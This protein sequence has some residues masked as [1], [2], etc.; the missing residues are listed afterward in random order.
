MAG[1]VGAASSTK[2]VVLADRLQPLPE[3]VYVY[4]PADDGLL[5][6]LSSASV[7][8]VF[9]FEPDAAWSV[10][11]RLVGLPTLLSIRMAML[12]SV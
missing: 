10:T 5:S 1:E 6:P 11:T 7:V 12:D 4:V 3:Q 2:Y 8:F 9:G